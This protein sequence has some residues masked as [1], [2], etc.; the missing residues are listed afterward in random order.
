MGSCYETSC[1]CAPCRW[2][3]PNPEPIP[4]IPAPPA[5]QTRT[6]AVNSRVNN[7]GLENLPGVRQHRFDEPI[8]PM[9]SNINVAMQ[10][11]VKQIAVDKTKKKQPR[12]VKQRSWQMVNGKMRYDFKPKKPKPTGVP[13]TIRET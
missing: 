2:F 6:I 3:W 10:V 4:Q 7:V 5:Q 12:H 1:W 8:D 13:K 9:T 11:N